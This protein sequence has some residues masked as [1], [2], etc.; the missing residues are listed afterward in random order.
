MDQVL[1]LEEP[2][3]PHKFI[4]NVAHLGLNI[5]FLNSKRWLKF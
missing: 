1:N 5:V 2:M 4:A 3:F